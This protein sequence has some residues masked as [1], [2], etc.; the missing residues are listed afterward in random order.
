[1]LPDQSQLWL[2]DQ[3]SNRYTCELRL[4]AVDQRAQA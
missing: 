4:L 1:M 3:D 2:Q